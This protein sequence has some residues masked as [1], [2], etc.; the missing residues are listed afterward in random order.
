MGSLSS[1]GMSAWSSS[2]ARVKTRHKASIMGKVPGEI[3]KRKG[4]GIFFG[5]CCYFW[6]IP[7]KGVVFEE[8]SKLFQKIVDVSSLECAEKILVSHSHT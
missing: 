1:V 6:E 8:K 7:Q 5:F 2:G 4:K 3:P